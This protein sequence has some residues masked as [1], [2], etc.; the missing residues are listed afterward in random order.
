MRKYP[1]GQPRPPRLCSCFSGLVQDKCHKSGK[2]VP[3][4]VHF[5]CICGSRKP[6]ANCVCSRQNKLVVDVWDDQLRVIR[7]LYAHA[8]EEERVSRIM[9]DKQNLLEEQQAVAASN[10]RAKRKKVDEEKTRRTTVKYVE[11]L[12]DRGVVDPAFAYA[13]KHA[14]DLPR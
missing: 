4:L 6:H 14:G 10:G 9:V 2:P 3:Y 8:W 1:S 5:Y 13:L 11:E 7:S 12:C